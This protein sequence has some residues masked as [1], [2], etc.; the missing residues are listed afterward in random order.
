MD[1]SEYAVSQGLEF[2]PAF[3][4]WV[5]FFLKKRE[6]IISLVK[7]RS[8]CYLKRDEKSGIALP[9]NIEEAYKLF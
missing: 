2:E 3:N 4:L 8:A 6:R 5:T 7:K 1:T 9:K